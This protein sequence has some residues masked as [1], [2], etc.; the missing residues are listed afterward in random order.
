ME[1]EVEEEDL[2]VEL[3][4]DLVEELEVDFLEGN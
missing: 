3:A 4:E 1:V 2:A